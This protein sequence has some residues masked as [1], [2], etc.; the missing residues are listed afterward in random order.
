[1][2][3]TISTLAILWMGIASL[4]AQDSTQTLFKGKPTLA[5]LGIM[6]DPGYQLTQVA[7]ESASFFLFRGGIVFN[8]KIT[9]GGFYGESL[10]QVRPNSFAGF[11]PSSAYIEAFQAGGFVEYTLFA[12]KVVH[13]TFPVSLGIIEL[14]IDE[15]GRGMDFEETQTFFVEP[16]AQVEINLHRFAR[17]H[18]GLGYRIMAGDIE[19]FPGVPDADNSLSFNVGLKM[20]LFRIKQQD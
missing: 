14:E 20:G 4:W 8:E 18:A 17:L 3:K 11:L 7:G 2:K 15:E 19:S 16:G 5:N 13:F 10:N 1:M 6:V 9:L 12:N